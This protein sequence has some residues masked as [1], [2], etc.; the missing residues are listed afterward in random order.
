METKNDNQDVRPEG[1]EMKS[2]IIAWFDNFFYHYKW[3]TIV[4]AFL[5]VVI[6][7]CS[8]Q[9][10][11]RTSYDVYIMYAGE[12]ILL[13]TSATSGTDPEYVKLS[14]ALMQY[15]EDFDGN[16][17]KSINLLNL[18]MP[19]KADIE[20]EDPEKQNVLATLAQTDSET[21][22]F[23]MVASH[24][25]YILF[26]SKDLF[27]NECT[28]NNELV[29]FNKISTY[30]NGDATAYTFVNDY[31]IELGSTELYKKGGF[32]LLPADTVI[33][34]RAP[35]LNGKTNQNYERSEAMLKALLKQG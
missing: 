20:A 7:I 8:F 9:M 25:F 17:E 1:V 19:T 28:S 27:L 31:G 26:L 29:P 33:C 32:N 24:E 30:T 15:A 34:M 35:L 11:N 10:C 6:L 3:H 13:K 23:N 5:I 2:P 16:G 14:S 4:C 12:K 22:N 18:Y 21:Y